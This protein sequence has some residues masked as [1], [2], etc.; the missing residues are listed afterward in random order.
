[1]AAHGDPER[2]EDRHHLD[3]A[4]D[5][6]PHVDRIQ[7]EIDHARVRERP[8]P[9]RFALPAQRLQHATDG[10]ARQRGRAE[11]RLQRAPDPPGICP[12]QIRAQNARIDRTG[13]PRIP[14]EDRRPP[15]RRGCR[16]KQAPPRHLHRRRPQTRAHFARPTRMTIPATLARLD[17][18]VALRP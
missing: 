8:G 16:R 12:R 2:H 4:I 9:P 18:R 15:L 10:T 13:P 6:D 1:M 17:A 14:W 11:Q 7:K 5:P 3:P